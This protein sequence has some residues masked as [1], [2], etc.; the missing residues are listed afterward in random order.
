MSSLLKWQAYSHYWTMLVNYK[1]ACDV[2]ASPVSICEMKIGSRTRTVISIF[3]PVA[4]IIIPVAL[5]IVSRDSKDIS[6]ETI[7]RAVIADLSNPALADYK[8]TYKNRTVSRLTVATIEVRNSGTRSVEA[9]DFERPLVLRFPG[10]DSIISATVGDKNPSE[11]T[12]VLEVTPKTISVAPLLLNPGDAFRL[13]ISIQGDLAEPNIDARIS[14]IHKISRRDLSERKPATS[15]LAIML[16]IFI[17][18]LLSVYFYLS[19]FI[20]KST[21]NRPLIPPRLD[22]VIILFTLGA[23]SGMAAAF[24]ARLVG[25]TRPQ[26]L[27]GIGVTL[28]LAIP[29]FYIARKRSVPAS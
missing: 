16:L 1:K 2:D 19:F 17:Y 21:R 22:S 6:V 10:S 11:L 24:A 28:L 25:L 3:V 18:V 14:G 20:F 7:S 27:L 29:F 4:G 5:Y 26:E 9:R 15:A 23:V 8:L 12:P 13:T